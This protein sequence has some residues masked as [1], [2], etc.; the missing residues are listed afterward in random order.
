VGGIVAAR[1]GAAGIPPEWRAACEP[2][3]AWIHG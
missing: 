2:L 3:P 1:V